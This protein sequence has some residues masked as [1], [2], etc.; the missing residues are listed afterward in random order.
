M[1]IT[2]WND[3][4][5]EIYLYLPQENIYNLKKI[6]KRHGNIHKAIENGQLLIFD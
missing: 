2:I 3:L 6:S 1:S 4:V 5:F